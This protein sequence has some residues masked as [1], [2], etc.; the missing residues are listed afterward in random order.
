MLESVNPAAEVRLDKRDAHTAE[1]VEAALALAV[2]AQRAWRAT[3][4]KR[5]LPLLR[6][7]ARRLRAGRAR[8]ARLITRQMGKPLTKARAEVEK[9]GYG[10]ELG[11]YGIKEFVNVKTVWFGPAVAS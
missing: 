3:P 1:E 11:E 6:A 4:L 2:T 10:P 8:F 9:S 5:R 7:I